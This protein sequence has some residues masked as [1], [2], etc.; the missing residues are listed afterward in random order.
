LANGIESNE[1]CLM[2]FDRCLS[3]PTGWG[4]DQ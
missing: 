1:S 4:I 2:G 3:G